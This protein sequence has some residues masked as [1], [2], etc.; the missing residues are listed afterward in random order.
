MN[1]DRS[2]LGKLL[3]LIFL[4]GLSVKVFI[5]CLEKGTIPLFLS[6]VAM[7]AFFILLGDF[8][9]KEFTS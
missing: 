9:K 4:M 7:V 5:H 2:K 6:F 1:S 8:V 3:S